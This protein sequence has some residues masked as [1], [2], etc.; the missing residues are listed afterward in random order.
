MQSNNKEIQLLSLFHNETIRKK[1]ISPV[2]LSLNFPRNKTPKS[3]LTRR[4]SLYLNKQKLKIHLKNNHKSESSNENSNNIFQTNVQNYMINKNKEKKNNMIKFC[5][6]KNSSLSICLVNKNY[7]NLNK[8]NKIP[9][10]KLRTSNSEVFNNLYPM[11]SKHFYF[12]SNSPSNNLSKRE[13][14]FCIMQKKKGKL[15]NK[16]S[17]NINQFISDSVNDKSSDIKTHIKNMIYNIFLRKKEEMNKKKMFLELKTNIK[18][19]EYK[20]K[21]IVHSLIRTQKNND[22]DL[23]KKG[24][25]IK[26]FINKKKEDF[27]SSL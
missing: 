23:K 18:K 5:K 24:F 1:L 11:T 20:V 4:N 9:K 21:E 27:N 10:I 12:K 13:R 22:S 6:K 17:R 7:N 26:N 15:S 2:I 16:H 8:E 14:N 3:S 19:N 25:I